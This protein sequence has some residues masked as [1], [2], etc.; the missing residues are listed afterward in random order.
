M[1]GVAI[2][3]H[4][5][6]IALDV[7]EEAVHF[8]NPHLPETRSEM[9]LPLVVGD[10]AI[11]AL[12]VQSVE[13]AAFTQEDI[14][15]LQAM[16]DQLAIAIKSTRLHRQNQT[17][18][19]R[20]E[21]HT[22]L[23]KAAHEVGRKV[24]SIL[25]MDVLLPN[26]VDIICEAYG[27]Y[28]AGVFLVD[29]KGEWAILRAGRGPAGEAM[30]AEGHKLQV[31]GHSMIGASIYLREARIALDV[32]EEAVHFKNPY[33]LHT[34]SEMALPLVVGRNVLG[35]V[36]VQSIEENA[37]S[38]DD[39]TMLQTMADQL[40]IAIHNAKLLQD[41]KSTHAE[42]LRTKT[43]EALATATTEAVHWIGNKALP[44]TTT[45][46]RMQQD[47]EAEDVDL[48][49]LSEDLEL[50][51]ESAQQIVQIKENLLGAARE[52]RPRPVMLADIWQAAAHDR[53]VSPKMIQIQTAPDTPLVLADSTQLVRALG[54]L[55][56]NAVEADAKN[57]RVEIAPAVEE[58][59]VVAHLRDDGHGIPED[60]QD[61]IWATFF[62]SKDVSH[63]G[64]GLAACLHVITQLDG[65]I[66][67]E[68]Q[69]GS[70]TTFTILLPAYKDKIT[71]PDF[72]AAPNNILLIDDDDEW[73]RFVVETLVG[74]GKTI[75]RKNTLNG[76]TTADIILVDQALESPPVMEIL[77]QLQQVDMIHKTILVAAGLK[78]ESIT[79][80]LQKGVQDAALKPYTPDELAKLFR[81]SDS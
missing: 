30:I 54:N 64:L 47:L 18:L 23:L 75:I 27:F 41:L 49:S 61:K 12:T 74:V 79:D 72:G 5:A 22:R 17:L 20:S 21:R 29:E 63:H 66:N 25:E 62:T 4:S 56:Q 1:V 10:E 16:A 9:A 80:Y 68:S 39:I 19:R 44:M 48:S 42:L 46:A 55:L 43:Y 57:I 33:L 69:E 45:I 73:A 34:R 15:V 7:G 31:G 81:P 40:A 37:F 38:T 8:Q 65:R 24:T 13:E 6:R 3:R 35:A 50:I 26:A 53:Q 28:Y 58:G 11:G 14:S 59:Y 51:A 76:A 78:V 52:Q 36:T 2:S 67:M 60:I 71:L 32:G 77:E 70:G